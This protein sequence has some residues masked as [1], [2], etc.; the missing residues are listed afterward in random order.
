MLEYS[1]L[2]VKK[3]CFDHS[4]FKKE[5]NKVFQYLNDEEKILFKK[6]CCNE[7]SIDERIL[8]DL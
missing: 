3:V 8:N 1:K 4:L 6:W 7:F 5:L 2:I